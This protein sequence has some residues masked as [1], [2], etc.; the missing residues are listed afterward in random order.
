MP[1]EGTSRDTSSEACAERLRRVDACAVSD[2]MDKLG[3]AGVVTGLPPRST[4]ARIAGRVV[5]VKLGVGNSPAGPV[6]HLGT[7]AVEAA[8]PGDVIVIEQRS[9]V[10]AGSWG[11]ILTQGARVRGVSGV[12]ADGP[13]RDIDE[14]RE[15]G[16]PVYARSCT[17]RTARGRIV[18][19]GTNVPVRIGD[20]DVT[21]GDYVIADGSA[22][23]FIPAREI[24]RVLDAAELIAHREAAMVEAIRAGRP[25][26][27][28]M[29]ANYEHLLKP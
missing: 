23:V 10:D 28:V 27:E 3:L 1:V 29:G 11:G 4:P 12:I 8:Q 21:P 26:T 6:R 19:Q 7:T 15:A 20:V 13:V 18:E 2:A 17:S 25:M 16:F 24:D 22:V 14:A 9:G 5:T